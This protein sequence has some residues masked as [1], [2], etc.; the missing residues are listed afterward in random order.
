MKIEQIYTG[1]LAEAAYFI[2]SDGEAAVID[3]LR[4]TEP[5]LELAQ[6]RGVNIKYVFETHF[7]ADFVSGH[8]DLAAKTGAKL[9]FG[10]E[11][12]PNYASYVAEDG[13]EFTIG[14]VT[15]KVLH[16]PG[17]TMESTTYLV[18]DEKG[19]D[20]AVFTGDTLFIGDVGRPDLAVK[21]DLTQDQLAGILYDSLHSKILTLADDVVVYPAHGAGSQCGKNMS[22][23]TVSTIGQQRKTNYA[24]QPMTREQFIEVVTD[25]LAAPPAYFSE[26]ARINREGYNSI[27]E[28]MKRNLNALSVDKFEKEVKEGAW[29]LDT[30]EAEDFEKEF[31]KG[32][33]NI[34]LR[35]QYAV[36]VGS[37]IPFNKKL[38][39]VTKTGDEEE[40]ILRLARVGYENVAGFLDGG[41]ETWKNAGRK[42]DTVKSINAADISGFV[43]KGYQLLDVRRNSEVDAEHIEGA[44]NISL[45]DLQDQVG[46]LK[47]DE[48]LVVHCAGGYRSMI[49]A[50]ILKIHGV[51]D[52]LNV[53][54]GFSAIKKD[55]GFNL[56]TGKC[57]TTRF[58]EK[59]EQIL[60]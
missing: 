59:L 53:L 16:T 26:N 11:A 41:V 45:I 10:P 32:S 7:H 52:I 2:E 37:L 48:K 21:S 31:V 24:L 3:P 19:K 5:Y 46:W 6:E 4:E 58:N 17:H 25:G 27:D 33:L 23:E 56:V 38:V 49:A 9:V 12:K 44:R 28:V 47:K 1:C 15:I 54:G 57:A 51:N 20:H 55:G 30:R 22:K 14:K 8:I 60:R 36:W 50:S 13:E 42:I 43:K 18:K 35:G 39:L 29:I 34:G 40:S